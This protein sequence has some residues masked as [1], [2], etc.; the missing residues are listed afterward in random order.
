MYNKD[1]GIWEWS[2]ENFSKYI[3]YTRYAD[4]WHIFYECRLDRSDLVTYH[5]IINL[6]R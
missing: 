1:E 4:I 3:T 6:A 2:K 5:K